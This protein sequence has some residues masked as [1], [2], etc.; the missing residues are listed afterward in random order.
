MSGLCVCLQHL[1][2]VFM[3]ELYDGG[4]RRLKAALLKHPFLKSTE[5]LSSALCASPDS[6]YGLSMSLL[7]AVG[8]KCS[9]IA[10]G[11]YR[12]NTCFMFTEAA[13]LS[14]VALGEKERVMQC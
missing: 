8:F 2:E 3:Y 5:E 12:A 9:L 13:R 6:I 10:S 14:S 7:D 4:I 1:G 11:R